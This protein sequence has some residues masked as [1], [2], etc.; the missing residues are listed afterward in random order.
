M[1][2]IRTSPSDPSETTL[3]LL[4]HTDCRQDSV[5]RYIG[6]IDLPLNKTGMEQ[7]LCLS[8]EL[9]DISFQR[10]YCS[11]LKRSYETARIVST[12]REDL[13]CPLAA[14]REINLGQWDGLPVEEVSRRFPEEYRM[15]GIDPANYRPPGG[16]SFNDLIVRVIPQYL[17]LIK[18]SRG[19][20]LIVGHAGVNRVILC[21]LLDM[22]L[23]HLFR[24]DQDYG[25]L[26]VIT[27]AGGCLK[28]LR[29]NAMLLPGFSA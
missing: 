6:Q 13:L 14:L 28:L 18:A 8:R 4:R 10:I 25:G 3:Y 24:L 26:N 11:D 7:A 21:N 1:N 29:M 23:S 20:I 2:V 15:R 5:K 19:N 27:R 9:K 16:E 17:K 22:P 12:G